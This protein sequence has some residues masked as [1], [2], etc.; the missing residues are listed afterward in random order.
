MQNA[1]AK[2][3][4]TS[5]RFICTPANP[6]RPGLPTPVTHPGASEVRQLD[7]YPGGDFV[8]MRCAA[9]GHEWEKELPQ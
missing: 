9:C 3:E 2:P 4:T 8:T 6:W 5:D 7:G 1:N